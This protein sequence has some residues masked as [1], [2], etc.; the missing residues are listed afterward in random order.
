MAT[1]SQN[2]ADARRMPGHRRWMRLVG[3]DTKP[4][5]TPAPSVTN[6]V[7][8]TMTAYRIGSNSQCGRRTDSLNRPST[9]S[10]G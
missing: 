2:T 6:A 1:P 7:A 10:G 5:N 9:C 8:A 3:S 4:S